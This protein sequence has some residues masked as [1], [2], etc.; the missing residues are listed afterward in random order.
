[1]PRRTTPNP[2]R[3]HTYTSRTDPQNSQAVAMRCIQ[4][5][6]NTRM[7]MSSPLS[8]HAAHTMQYMVIT[9]FH[10]KNHPWGRNLLVP[11]RRPCTLVPPKRVRVVSIA[12]PAA[13]TPASTCCAGVAC[14]DA[15]RIGWRGGEGVPF[16]VENGRYTR[17]TWDIPQSSRLFLRA[18]AMTRT[19]RDTQ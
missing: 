14:D 9:T 15:S 5:A 19:D 11:A 6:R 8:H 1:M 18:G 7:S 16:Y 10:P 17:H 12:S 13:D 3:Q 4:V 2:A